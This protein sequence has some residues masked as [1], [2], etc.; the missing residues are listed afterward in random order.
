M[1]TRQFLFT[2]S[3]CISLS[4]SLEFD[5]VA[6]TTHGYLKGKVKL[7]LHNKKYHSFTGIPYAK[8]P[9]G[10][11][12]FREPQDLEPWH[13]F[14]R[15]A[16][17][18]PP[19]CIQRNYLFSID[20]PIEG[21]ED[22]LYLNLFVPQTNDE[23]AKNKKGL[24]PVMVF[25]HWGGFIAGRSTTGYLGPEYFM[26][27]DVILVT[28]NYRVGPFGF[29][30]TLDDEAPGNY[31]LKD[32]VAA[33]KWVRANVELFG[34]DKDKVTIFGQSAGAGSVHLHM[35]N[36]ASK[37]LFHRAISQSGNALAGWAQPTTNL[38]K[39]IATLQG[40][41]VG[42]E[43]GLNNTGDLIRCLK[44][45][46]AKDILKSQDSFR[47]FFGNPLMVFGTVVETKSRN[48]PNPFI[49]KMPL[50]SILDGEISK[51]PWLT[52]V[53]K[54]EGILRAAGLIRS[55]R[56]R[57]TLNENFEKL[58][59]EILLILSLS[60]PHSQSLYRNI[61]NFYLNGKNFIDIDDS[62]NIQGFVDVYSDRAF[63]YPFYQSVIL[64][65]QKGHTPIYLYSFEY[66]GANTYGDL[67]A[68]THENINF[69]WGTCHSDDLLYL[70]NSPDLFNVTGA[71]KDSQLTE[72][73]INMWTNFAKN[74]HPNLH[75]EPITWEPLNL[76]KTDCLDYNSKFE[77]LNIT[78]N[79][80]TGPKLE[81]TN[82]FYKERMKFWSGS[83]I[84]ENQNLSID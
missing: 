57:D 74:G 80:E 37:G 6:Y 40:K 27:K 41:F 83:D 9:V 13:N 71:F 55:T 31:G 18:D 33:L 50:Q 19:A 26:D 2:W 82:G 76:N 28:F 52:G 64:Q 63:F 70:F 11:L 48:N 65:S 24:L 20:P 60:T 39:E 69:H 73:L 53:V 45:I 15:D 30:S 16:T 68:M 59:S 66:E 61:S 1:F 3:F 72:I 14:T 36:P 77:L 5:P 47:P 17:K 54:N 29:L 49:L 67:F 81:I 23:T 35:L 32:Q 44:S 43:N 58:V 22:C 10:D 8:A 62:D 75:N 7:S 46:P 4:S 84:Y 42:C 56:V 38:Q 25:I 79:Y 34:G 12:R 78:G 21:K 51:V